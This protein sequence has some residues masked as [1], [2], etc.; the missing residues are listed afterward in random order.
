MRSWSRSFLV[1]LAA[2]SATPAW[3]KT[4]ADSAQAERSC[5]REV[6]EGALTLVLAAPDDLERTGEVRTAPEVKSTPSRDAAAEQRERDFLNE[7]W[8]LP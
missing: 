2:A 6:R 1:V 3:A 7:I 4:A 5:S 8:T